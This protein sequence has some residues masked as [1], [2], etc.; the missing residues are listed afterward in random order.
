MANE[1]GD[2]KLLAAF[3]N[4]SIAGERFFSDLVVTS[5]QL[6]FIPE[7]VFMI[8]RLFLFAIFFLGIS[9]TVAAGT[10]GRN[11]R[12]LS[13]GPVGAATVYAQSTTHVDSRRHRFAVETDEFLT[14]G[15]HISAQARV[16]H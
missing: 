7:A 13:G 12:D 4:L 16:S 14:S 6:T 15:G 3:A 11:V 8:A 10:I 5:Q 1:A 9:S 2:I